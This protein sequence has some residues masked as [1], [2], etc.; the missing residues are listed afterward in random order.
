MVGK[1]DADALQCGLQRARGVQ[2]LLT[3]QRVAA[4][5]VVRQNDRG[6]VL[7]ERGLDD[8]AYADGGNRD[9]APVDRH[10]AKRLA[11][12][13][14]TQKID[15]LF[16][17]AVEK[18]N[19]ILPALAGGVQDIRLAAAVDEVPPLELR[20]QAEKLRC[21]LLYTSDAADE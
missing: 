9:A 2:I 1:H 7:I 8:F 18:R 16:L 17:L 10:A 12:G 6:G 14:Q 19:E 20:N 4:R 3:R 15:N 5:V 11:L 21:C 13:V